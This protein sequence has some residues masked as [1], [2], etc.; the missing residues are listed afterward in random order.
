LSFESHQEVDARVRVYA[1]NGARLADLKTWLARAEQGWSD[2]LSA[3]AA[4]VAKR[5]AR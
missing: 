5:A 4:H 2:Q 1:L 3:F